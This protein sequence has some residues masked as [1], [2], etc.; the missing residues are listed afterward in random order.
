MN[1]KILLTCF[2]AV[3]MISSLSVGNLWVSDDVP[4]RGIQSVDDPNNEFVMSDVIETMYGNPIYASSGSAGPDSDSGAYTD[5]WSDTQTDYDGYETTSGT[6]YVILNFTTEEIEYKTIVGFK[7]D[8]HAAGA[9]DDDESKLYFYDWT[10]D[11]WTEK[12]DACGL[13][14][15][16]WTETST[17]ESKY[18]NEGQVSIKLESTDSDSDSIAAI[19]VAKMSILYDVHYKQLVLNVMSFYLTGN[20]VTFGVQTNYDDCSFTIWDNG[21]LVG[22][23]QAQGLYQIPYSNVV[24]LHV[25]DILVNGSHSGED[26]TG[27][28]WNTS[29]THKTWEWRT[30]Q[31]T[32]NPV[33]LVITELGFQQNNETIIVSGW[34][35]TPN[36]TL[37]WTLKEDG[38]ETGNGVLEIPASGSYNSI[39]WSK[40]LTDVESNF[41]LTITADGS[42]V[43]INGY[44]F[45]IDNSAFIG[46]SFYK[47]GSTYY[48]IVP[49]EESLAVSG[50]II[51]V[52]VV[53]VA[54]GLG[55]G[56]RGSKKKSKG[57]TSYGIGRKGV[58]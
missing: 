6:S 45:V 14:V 13:G 49:T 55:Y 37:T 31:Y 15:F 52:I 2:I 35:L 48:Q 18:F 12:R 4:T 56:M 10:T 39:L 41:T 36:T 11:V 47:E 25:F 57:D 53:P 50:L 27:Q 38:I 51:A 3:L 34:F 5:T 17:T 54:I 19:A 40:T 44:S 23:S 43:V 9:N 7:V 58:I 29:L 22:Y 24:G 21:S 16:I 46:G 26:E 8:M 33:Q 20:W 30:F 42:S 28:T 32:V 1:K